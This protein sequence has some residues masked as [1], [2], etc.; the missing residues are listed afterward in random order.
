MSWQLPQGLLIQELEKVIWCELLRLGWEIHPQ[1][2]HPWCNHP[3]ELTAPG[4]ITLMNWPPLVQ[5]PLLIDRPWCNHPYELTAPVAIILMNWPPLVQLNPLFAMIL[6]QN[7]SELFFSFVFCHQTQ[8]QY[9]WFPCWTKF[10]N[11]FFSFKSIENSSQV[12]RK[13]VYL[14]L[15]NWKN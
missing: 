12:S 4:A 15:I 3:Y 8:E 10:A 5:S 9:F 7:F 13:K 6:S 11:I 1:I 14:T 2:D